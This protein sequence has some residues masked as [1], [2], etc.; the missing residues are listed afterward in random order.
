MPKVNIY[1][2]K[3]IIKFKLITN[4]GDT[5]VID[6][7]SSKFDIEVN[8]G[9]VTIKDC[10]FDE[11]ETDLSAGNL[12]VYTPSFI[13]KIDADVT[14]GNL[15]L[16]LSKA[17]SGFVCSYD[18]TA[19]S[20]DNDTSFDSEDKKTDAFINESGTIVYGDSA[21]RIDIELTAGNVEL[22]DYR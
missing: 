13:R 3:D 21:C 19:G 14:A 17:I 16:Y 10:A 7:T 6:L 20:F 15:N 2:P 4:A 22:K 11:I 18:V 5:K 9:N 8:A 12:D 1:L